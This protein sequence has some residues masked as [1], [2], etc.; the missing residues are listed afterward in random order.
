LYTDEWRTPLDYRTAAEVLCGLALDHPE[1]TGVLHVG[2]PE[3]ISRYD[4]LL[5]SARCLGLDTGLIEPALA[6]RTVM[7]EPRPQDVSLATA[8]LRKVM[9]EIRLRTVEEVVG[10]I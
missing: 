1:V 2:G 5:R 3:R 10:G 8:R 9:P 7:P 6:T 4:L